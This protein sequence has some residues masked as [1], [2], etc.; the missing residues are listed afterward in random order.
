MACTSRCLR[1]RLNLA[2]G[3]RLPSWQR[4][5]GTRNSGQEDTPAP[6][7]FDFYPSA[8]RWGGEASQERLLE[9]AAEF[10]IGRGIPWMAKTFSTQNDRRTE[11]TASENVVGS[12]LPRGKGIG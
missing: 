6:P 3:R 2:L 9:M 8:F 5:D 7:W 4:G 1:I 11:A 12:C 10:C